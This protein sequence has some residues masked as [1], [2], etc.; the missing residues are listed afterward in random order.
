MGDNTSKQQLVLE[1]RTVRGKKVSSLRAQSLIPGVVYGGDT[2][3]INIQVNQVI[4]EKAYRKAGQH[5]PLHLTIG[6]KKKIAMIKEVNYDPVKHQINHVAFHAVKQNEPVI[7]D[8][9]IRLIDQ[10]E[11]AAEKAGLII[12]QTLEKAEVKALPMDLPDA[13]E[14]STKH[15]VEPGEKVTLQDAKLPASVEFVE[16]DDGHHDNEDERQSITDQLVASVWEPAALQ[17]Q[18]EAA[19]GDAEEADAENVEAENGDDTP[20]T[21]SDESQASGDTD[22][23]T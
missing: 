18:N 4:F 3:P 15:L 5:H 13:I 2:E 19:A 8:I 11:S 21:N 16:H 20:Q 23:K 12:L 9:P 17:A 6:S 14:I 10:G 1:E 22:A 7:A